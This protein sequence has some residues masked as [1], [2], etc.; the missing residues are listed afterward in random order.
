MTDYYQ[1][2]GIKETANAGEIKSAYRKLARKH[3]PDVNHGSEK[4]EREFALLSLAYHTLIDPQERAYHDSQLRKQRNGHSILD[5]DNPHAQRARNIAAQARW[6]RVVNQIL[7]TDRRENM[8]RQ[9]AVFTTVS[10]FLSTFFVA[11]IKPP[12]WQSFDVIGR[13]ILLILF[14]AGLWHLVRRLVEHFRHYTYRK[15]AKHYSITQEE[16]KPEQPFTRFTGV[17]F[18]V[19]GYAISLALGLLIG[20]KA[21]DFF[22]DLTLLFRH[23]VSANGISTFSPDVTVILDLIFYPPI[24]VL[25]I[26]SLHAVASRI[27]TG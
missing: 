16:E 12:L 22:S 9:R 20:W 14:A 17:A 26:D 21:Q 23:H 3:H 8:E 4:A 6:D 18:L 5:S 7:E 24:A 19:V 2:L 1:V 13:A 10:L 27:D 11:M 25:I 15:D